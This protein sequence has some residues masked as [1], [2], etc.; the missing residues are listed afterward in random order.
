MEVSSQP[1][2][3]PPLHRYLL[4]KRRSGPQVLFER[5]GEEINLITFGGDTKP[6]SSSPWSGHYADYAVPDAIF[7]E[8]QV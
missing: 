6:G 4:N 5:F 8:S 7:A 2:A 1:D 3:P